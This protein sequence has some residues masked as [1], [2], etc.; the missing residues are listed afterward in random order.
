[1]KTKQRSTH[2]ERA[3]AA[4]SITLKMEVVAYIEEEFT[5]GQDGKSVGEHV[6][7]MIHTCMDKREIMRTLTIDLSDMNKE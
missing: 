5:L 3:D 1:M 4:P 7:T 6:D 2:V